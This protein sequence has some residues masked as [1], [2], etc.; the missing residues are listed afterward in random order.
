MSEIIISNIIT[1]LC[2]GSLAWLFTV[3]FTRKE[4]EASAMGKVQEVYQALIN[5]LQHDRDNL[6]T[7]LT[8]MEQRV[9]VLEVTVRNNERILSKTSPFLCRLAATCKVREKMEANEL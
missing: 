1:G 9:N 5:D 7:R 4:A 8:D 2:T 6:K 3:K